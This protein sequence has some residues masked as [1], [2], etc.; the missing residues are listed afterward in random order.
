MSPYRGRRRDRELRAARRKHS[1]AR[2]DS[3]FACEPSPAIAAGSLVDHAGTR[4]AHAESKKDNDESSAAR[5]RFIANKWE[6]KKVTFR[7]PRGS[8]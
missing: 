5:F 1:V 2:G 4:A 6:S 8:F 3:S 7:I